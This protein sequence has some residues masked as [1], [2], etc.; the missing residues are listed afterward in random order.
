VF[1]AF[2]AE[3]SKNTGQKGL[4]MPNDTVT[5]QVELLTIDVAILRL[6][7]AKML[8]G[9]LAA[10]E[11]PDQ[12]ALWRFIDETCTAMDEDAEALSAFQAASETKRA[13]VETFMR[14]NLN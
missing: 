6:V 3:L 5:R 12:I 2:S 13:R 7:V 8:T 1:C 4:S 11:E 14:F 10:S 9:V